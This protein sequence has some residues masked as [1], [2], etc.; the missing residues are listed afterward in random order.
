MAAPVIETCHVAFSANETANVVSWGRGWIAAIGTQ[1]SIVLYDVKGMKVLNVLN[2]HTKRVNAVQWVHGQDC[3][4]E[5]HIV[6]GGSDNSVLIWEV[7]NTEFIRRVECKGHTGGVF[8]VDGIHLNPSELLVASSSADCTVRLWLF[9]GSQDVECLH[10]LTFGRGFMMD[11]AL[12][13]L[14]G[15][16]VP[17][18]A[19]G[20]DDTNVHLYVE[21]DKV[22]TKVLTLQGHE[23]WLR[24]VSWTCVDGELLLASCSQDATI[25]VWRLWAKSESGVCA[26]DDDEIKMKEEVFN[27]KESDVCYAVSLETVLLGHDGWVYGIHWHPPTYTGDELKQSLSLLSASMDQTMVLWSPDK[28]SGQWVE[29]VRVGEVG[30]NTMGFLGCQMSPDGSMMLAHAY[31]G[32]LHLWSK[33]QDNEEWKPTVVTSG[34]FDE[35][36]DLSW[37]PEGDFIITVSSDQTAR[38]FTP[39]RSKGSKEVTWHEVSRPQI[40]GYNIQCLAMV[41]RF[42]FVSGADEKVLRV[43]Q[44]PLNFVNNFAN[45]S[46]FSAEELMTS[47]NRAS[48]PEGAST[49]ALG[50]SNKA[51]YQGDLAVKAEQSAN[52]TD[53]ISDQY[54]E[55]D[56]HPRNI[57]E[58]P[59]EDYL[60]QNTR[61]PEIQKL[62]GHGFEMF[63]LA[64]DRART[65]VASACKATKAEHASVLLWSTRTWRQLQALSYHTLTVTQLAFSPD[66]QMLLA[67]ARDRTWSLWRRNQPE[68]EGEEPRFSLYAQTG[69]DTTLHERI[70]WSCDWSPDSRYFAT[71]SRDKTVIMWGPCRVV[72]SGDLMQPDEIKCC[73]V[74][75]V[76]DSATAVAFCPVVHSDR[77][78]LAVGLECGKVVF[79]SWTP[80]APAGGQDWSRCGETDQSQSHTAAVKRLRWRPRAGRAGHQNDKCASV[81]REKEGQSET[82]ESC[83][84]QLASASADHSVKI[85]SVNTRTLQQQ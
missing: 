41:G 51:V 58:P 76:G 80:A 60:H 1:H 62:Y 69:K 19:C 73:S 53:R 50:L 27:V 75:N 67:V 11:V 33:D 13:M 15:S 82:G 12:S 44:A 72:A 45:I 55:P 79:H 5:T 49:P 6:S 43:F 42:Q 28:E 54:K 36:Q 68:S 24:G 84:V 85:F 71:S 52:Q 25:R 37:D 83:R 3:A 70:I 74:L 39:W 22:L 20:G 46:G 21:I 81:N 59:P 7:Q 14:P 4:P 23:D 34:H 48:L 65:V 31:H 64:S 61:W 10:V 57:T 56:F 9:K 40:H 17:V 47:D 8:A 38:L 30:E 18:L 63:C 29:K 66:S 2:G 32:A 16:S 26:G 35:V 78:L 77:Y